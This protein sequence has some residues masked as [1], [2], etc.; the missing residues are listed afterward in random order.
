MN[1]E[2]TKLASS[3]DLTCDPRQNGLS[4]VIL[5]FLFLGKVLKYSTKVRQNFI[6]FANDLSMHHKAYTEQ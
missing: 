6:M 4:N 1:L 5:L 2:E 3:Q